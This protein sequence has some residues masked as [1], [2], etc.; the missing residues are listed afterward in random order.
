[1]NGIELDIVDGNFSEIKANMCVAKRR[2]VR[3]HMI[4]KR[5]SESVTDSHVGP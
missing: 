5:H 4:L 3:R 1:V 2:D